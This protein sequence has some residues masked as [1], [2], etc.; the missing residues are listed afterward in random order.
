MSIFADLNI[1]NSFSGL[2]DDFYSTVKPFAIDNPKLVSINPQAAKLIHL[3]K[4]ALLSDEFLSIMAC[5]KLPESSKP[6]AT[7][8][9]G[10]QF[11]GYS[12]QLGDGRALLFTEVKNKNHQI[13]ELQLK[14]SGLTPYSRMGDGRAVLRSTIREYLCSE[15]M[16]GLGIPTTRALAIANSTTPVYREEVETAATLLRMAPSHIRFGH[17]EYFFYTKQHDKLKLLAD[18]VIEQH[19]PELATLDKAQRYAKWFDTISQRTATLIAKWQAA[20][21]AHGVMN[22]DNMSI[23]GLTLDYGPFGFLDD[24]N[25][26]YICNHSDHTGRYAFNQQLSIGLW[27]LNALAYALSPL[28]NEE[29][30]KATLQQYEELFFKHYSQLMREK[31]GLTES[32]EEDHALIGKLFDLLASEK[33][34]Y[35]FFFRQLSHYTNAHPSTLRDIFIDRDAFDIW[36]SHYD[37]RLKKENS[38]DDERQQKMKLKNPKFIL[39]NYLAH[40]AIEKANADDFT[41]VDDLLKVLQDPFDEHTEHEMLAKLPPD[42]GKKLEVSCSS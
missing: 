27:N 9:S 33:Q 3:D 14:G 7:V 35:S 30:R 6:L 29:D 25:P 26:G 38:V 28:I 41:M 11:G 21:F 10:H 8:Y 1:T 5:E 16:H 13:W 22:T 42:W 20:G 34:D 17:F 19:F 39:R 36:L 40:Q 4:D 15:A 2:P 18:Y 31:L 23:L 37:A 12:P 32:H 24:F